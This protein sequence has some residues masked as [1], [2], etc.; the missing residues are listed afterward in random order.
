MNKLIC[1]VTGTRAEYGLLRKLISRLSVDVEFDLRLIVTGAHLSAKYGDTYKEIL[2]DGVYIHRYVDIQLGE[3]TPIGVAKST[4]ISISAMAEVFEELKPQLVLILGDRYEILGTA[5][6]AMFCKIPIAHFHGGELTSGAM[7]DAIRHAITKLSHLHF[8]A[9]DTYRNRVIQLGEAAERVVNVGGLGVDAINSIKFLDYESLEKI[10]G[11][12]FKKKLYLVTYHPAT[13]DR[14]SPK[15]QVEELLKAL[16]NCKDATVIFTMPNSDIGGKEID[17][18][19]KNFVEKNQ[20]SYYFESLGQL[21]Y[22]SCMRYADIVIGNSSS[23]I[24]EAPAL[25]VPTV[26]IGTRQN[27]RMQAESI[28]NC[29]AIEKHISAAIVKAQDK[30]FIAH[31]TKIHQP[32]GSEDAT[33]KIIEVLKNV[34]FE[35]LLQ[36]SFGDLP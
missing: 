8:V 35:D 32:Y 18:M 26:N 27:G 5:I 16:E 19:V 4:G 24:I 6:A 1:V 12:K 23:G 7:D 21:K 11:V 34:K 15:T 22:L 31:I 2:D 30:E 10:L 17:E 25:G 14:D 3:D 20:N 36:K 9:N 33:E 28:I 29:E 13:L